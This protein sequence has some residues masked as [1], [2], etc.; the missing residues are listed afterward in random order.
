MR[1]TIRDQAGD[2]IAI[3]IKFIDKPIARTGDVIVLGSVLFSKGDIKLPIDILNIEGSITRRE[4]GI[5]KMASK[6]WSS[7]IALENVD[8]AGAKLAA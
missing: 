6:I 5:S 4:I 3:Q 7:G 1:G 8:S 2:Q